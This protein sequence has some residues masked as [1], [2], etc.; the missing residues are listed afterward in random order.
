MNDRSLP[1][2]PR[3]PGEKGLPRLFD[4]HDVKIFDMCFNFGE[5]FTGRDGD[6]EMKSRFGAEMIFFF[7]S[8]G[9]GKLWEMCY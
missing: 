4:R 3:L 6:A 9:D 7:F 1:L 2:V 8:E 5:L